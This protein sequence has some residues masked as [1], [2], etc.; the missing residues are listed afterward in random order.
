MVEVGEKKNLNPIE[1]VVMNGHQGMLLE[2]VDT[3]LFCIILSCAHVLNNVF[4]L[5]IIEIIVKNH[6]H[7]NLK[8]LLEL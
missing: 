4:K 5:F 8:T 6:Q 1:I 2:I 3:G 7:T